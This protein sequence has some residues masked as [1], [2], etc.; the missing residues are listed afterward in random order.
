MAEQWQLH[1]FK[2]ALVV[3][4]TLFVLALGIKD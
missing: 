2:K 3:F 1:T 4:H